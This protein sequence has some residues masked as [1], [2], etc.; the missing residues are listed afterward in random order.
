[1]SFKGISVVAALLSCGVLFA[2]GIAQ[3]ESAMAEEAFAS[4]DYGNAARFY[5]MVRQAAAADDD[6]EK[7]ISSTLSLARAKVRLGDAAGARKLLDEFRTRHP[8]HSPG[9]LPGEILAAEGKI[10]EA[11]EYLRSFAASAKDP[12]ERAQAELALAYLELRFGNAS[13]S[14]EA[15]AKLERDP[16]LA[17]AARTLRIYGLIRAGR[18]VEAKKLLDE[19]LPGS[20]ALERLHLRVLALLADL[21]EGKAEKFPAEWEAL[22]TEL[23]PHPDPLVFDTLDEAA[24]LALHANNP[25]RA[26]PL[27]SSAYDFADSDDTRRDALRKLFN[28]YAAYDAKLAAATAKRYAEYFPGATDRARLLS[29]AGRLLVNAGDPRTALDYFELVLDDRELLAVERY[30]AA[31]D[32]ALAAERARDPATARRC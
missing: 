24:K 11:E 1:M 29:G 10:S 6:A 13:A 19:T 23:R 5:E 16:Q 25:Q 12:G 31:R 26:A 18:P 8:A 17:A 20:G 14:L 7:W 2:Y 4:G 27:W 32:A 15:L 21:R 9:L 30:E 3:P 22:R 28:C